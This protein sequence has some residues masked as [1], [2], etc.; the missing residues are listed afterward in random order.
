MF[1]MSNCAK[2]G[3]TLFKVVEQS[4]YGSNFKLMFVQCSAC[5]VPI[6]VVNYYDTGAQ[7]V[8]Q[9]QLI[10]DFG[11][12]LSNVESMLGRIIRSLQS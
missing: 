3:G 6:G 12:R 5:N 9:K 11:S 10:K 8:E 4:P 1:G 2:C 7:L